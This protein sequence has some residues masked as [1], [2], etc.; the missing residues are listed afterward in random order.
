MSAWMRN[1]SVVGV[2]LLD[3]LA[4]DGAIFICVEEFAP[5]IHSPLLDIP[6]LE[7]YFVKSRL[8]V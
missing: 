3:Y 2:I 6:L 7:Q 4:V 8:S 5:P 1:C